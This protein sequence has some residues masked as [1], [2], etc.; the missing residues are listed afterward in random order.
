[1]IAAALA[2]TLVGTAVTPVAAE[3]VTEGR[4]VLASRDDSRAFEPVA[5]Q[6]PGGAQDVT[7]SFAVPD[8]LRV[9]LWAESP[10][11]YNPT[12]I[13]VD[14]AGR[15]WVAEAVNY[16]KWNGRNPGRDHPD[17]DRIVVLEDKD[18]DGRA[19]TSTVF[20]QDEDLVAPLGIAVIGDSVFVSCSPTI[21][22]YRDLDGD[23]RS[24]EKTVF[25]TGFGGHDHDHGAHSLVAGPDGRL[26][27]AVGN[28]GPHIVTDAS[29]W[30]L[31][32]GS[33]YSG[34]G[35]TSAPNRPGLVSDDGRKWTGGLIL[36]VNEDGTGLRV[37][38]HNFRNPYEVALDAFGNVFTSD[39][40]DDGNACCRLVP[41]MQG[42]DYGF[43]SEDGARSWQADRLADQDVWRAHW[44]QDDPGI[45]PA[46][47]RNGAGGPTG[48]CGYE[49]GL[50]PKRFVGAVLNCDA[51][52]GVVYAHHPKPDGAGLGF[53]REDLIRA[54]GDLGERKQRWF[55][56]SD[57][58]VGTD[59]AIYVADWYDPGVGGHG[60]GDR[61]AYGRILRIAPAGPP[62][63]VD[64]LTLDDPLTALSSPAVNVRAHAWSWLRSSPD[65]LASKR[66]FERW[67]TDGDD[68]DLAPTLWLFAALQR[69]G[70]LS[71]FLHGVPF[72]ERPW[73]MVTSMRALQGDDWLTWN[74][75]DPI[76][77]REA[78]LQLRGTERESNRR[79][80]L[81]LAR[82]HVVGDRSYLEAL[83]FAFEGSEEEAYAALL[84]EHGKPPTQ[85]P[86]AF[87]EIAWRLHPVSSA[88]AF[89]ARAFAAELSSE[90]RA[91]AVS[92][93][94]FIDDARAVDGM[95]AL[96]ESGPADVQSLA[97]SW[98]NRLK[99]GR[100]SRFDLGDRVGSA[101]REGARRA[102]ATDRMSAGSEQVDV[103]LEGAT[104]L[105]LVV[106]DAGDGNSHDW[107][108]F[109]DARLTG[110][111]GDL[112]LSKATWLKN[113]TGWGELNRDRNAG[114]APLSIGGQRFA[115]GIGA[116]APA[117]ITIR[118]PPGYERLLATV[119]P[120]DGGTRQAGSSTS[121]S[122]EI[123]LDKGRDRSA[124]DAARTTLLD[125]AQPIDARL[126]AART[127]TAD[128]EGALLLAGLAADR[129]LPDAIK[130][131]VAEPLRSHQDPRVRAIAAQAFARP[132]S[133]ATKFAPI[134][135]LA[136]RDGDP[137][138]GR[139]VFF[140]TRAQCAVC[141]VHSGRGGELGPDLTHIAEK[142]DATGLLAA[143]LDPS[144][145]ISF[146][147]ETWSIATKDGGFHF[148]FLL[149]DGPRIV[150]KDPAGARH[151]IDADDVVTRTRQSQSLMPDTIALG[152]DEQE[153]VDLVAYLRWRPFDDLPLAEPIALF[154]GESLRGWTGHFADET[155]TEDVFSVQDGLL[156][157]GG[158]PIGYLRTAREFTDFVLT[159]EW[160][161]QGQPGN[162][163]V[164]VRQ[165]GTDKVWPKSIEC[166]LQ[167]GSAGDIWN[168]DEFPMEVAAERT[169]GRRTKKL[170][171]SSENPLG[172]WNRYEIVLN[173]GALRLTVN[174]VVQNVAFACAHV[175][176]HIVLQ[177]EGS[178]IEFRKVE[179][180][181]IRR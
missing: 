22:R 104:T 157:D 87:A 116:H 150:L 158:A 141:H 86:P 31:R 49:Q 28:A 147:Y 94:A 179:L 9:T 97:W 121:I 71:P 80:R 170:A 140:G 69:R 153:L 7:A 143:I 156:I 106:T 11:L 139:T 125:V 37:F 2:L 135:E 109:G 68:R 13:D 30:T 74:G 181:E 177:A 102:F 154:D 100:W 12:A 79:L 148:G 19:E 134:A 59:G 161:F 108:C 40:D 95:L 38:A 171:P 129:R 152:I 99:D 77:R 90:D 173:R 113:S 127:L 89:L 168:I 56:P 166:Q 162:G 3:A 48:V 132:G 88:P 159:V 82:Q 175:P 6:Q 16:R 15:I 164:L 172:E 75:E 4:R 47:Y 145:A 32:S 118:V 151:V 85:W 29:G 65:E 67:S 53:E 51:G 114:G 33:G 149:A 93:L 55:R 117:E 163:G 14:S 115:S 131:A 180:R 112:A 83:G 36:S 42:G 128:P 96:A 70:A 133:A 76:T 137:G 123:W 50:L 98:L 25:L 5:P 27:F 167:S 174:G 44:H 107:A 124:F 10:Q 26:W 119:G 73:L 39:N 61:E 142:Y 23:L 58:C 160:R 126:A 45:A 72:A 60:M 92:A 66:L 24:D 144:A 64:P 105:W 78:L 62:R 110:P 103:P 41:V 111:A 21:W 46:G 130:N 52:A 35:S 91:R 169:E 1:M 84:A 165:V 57:V 146:G 43:F 8:D 20:V 34:G 63:R 101:S 176:G 122:F 120:D 136:A 138:R 18:G 178:A 17:G 54:T 81:D 155:R